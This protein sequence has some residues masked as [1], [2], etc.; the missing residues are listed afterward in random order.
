MNAMRVTSLPLARSGDGF[1]ALDARPPQDAR[2]ARRPVLAPFQ[3]VSFDRRGE[4]FRHFD[5][6]FGRYDDRRARVMDRAERYWS[7]AT[8]HAYN[9]QTRRM[10]RIEQV[11]E[12]AGGHVLRVNDPAVY[13]KYLTQEAMQ[14]QGG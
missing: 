12:V 8:V 9:V 10:T 1:A 7:W 4:L 2:D 11:R 13:E 5:A 3:M 6:S 14:R